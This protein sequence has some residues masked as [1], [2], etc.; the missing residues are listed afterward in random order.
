[1]RSPSGIQRLPEGSGAASAKIYEDQGSRSKRGPVARK[2]GGQSRGHEKHQKEN[3]ADNVEQGTHGIRTGNGVHWK[4]GAGFLL[5]LFINVEQHRTTNGSHEDHHYGQSNHG[6]FLLRFPC[7][8][9]FRWDFLPNR[10]KSV[11]RKTRVSCFKSR[12]S[13]R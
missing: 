8:P 3:A 7:K 11:H 13:S 10:R 2:T 12:N 5:H 1:P 4:Q 9:L 6:S